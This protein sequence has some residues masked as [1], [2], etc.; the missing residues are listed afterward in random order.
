M[1]FASPIEYGRFRLFSYICNLQNS[2][3]R[4]QATTSSISSANRSNCID[5]QHPNL[6]FKAG[7]DA[8]ISKS[9]KSQSKSEVQ[10]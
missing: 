7:K 8:A 1:L 6:E 4:L 10:V 9:R 5:T 3:S 2:A